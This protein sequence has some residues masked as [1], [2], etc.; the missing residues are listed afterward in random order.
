LN[1]TRNYLRDIKQ[2]FLHINDLVRS[3]KHNNIL[4]IYGLAF[5]VSEEGSLRTSIVM[6]YLPFDLRHYIRERLNTNQ[7]RNLAILHD[8]L[9]ALVYF[10]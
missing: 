5:D 2:Y 6:E 1:S 3:I 4:Y 10:K 8:V 9:D 7:E